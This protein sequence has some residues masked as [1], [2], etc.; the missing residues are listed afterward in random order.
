MKRECGRYERVMGGTMCDQ[1]AILRSELSAYAGQNTNLRNDLVQLGMAKDGEIEDL[2]A[3]LA[4]SDERVEDI[5]K[6]GLSLEAQL[7]SA[8]KALEE[9]GEHKAGCIREP[10]HGKGPVICSCGLAEVASALTDDFRQPEDK[11]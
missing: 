9:Y 4:T 8:R 2:R 1:C 11:S 7:A 3:R 6:H 5:W 10:W